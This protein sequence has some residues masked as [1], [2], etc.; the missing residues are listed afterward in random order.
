MKNI[1]TEETALKNSSWMF[2]KVNAI[3]FCIALFVLGLFA[4]LLQK[5]DFSEVEKRELAKIPTPTVE[6]VFSARFMKDFTAWYADTFPWRDSFITTG[7]MIEDTRG[8]RPD[9][10]KVYE[11]KAP[12]A[13][14]DPVVK[15]SEETS[16]P[17]E[18]RRRPQRVPVVQPEQPEISQP[19]AV[20]P[21]EP[22]PDHIEVVP[23]SDEDDVGYLMDNGIFVF[24]DRA[25]NLFGGSQRMADF[26]ASTLNSYVE[27]LDSSVQTYN[28]VVPCSAEFYLPMRYRSRSADQWDNISY[29][30]SQLDERIKTV[31]AYNALAAHA[32]EYIY[33]R[34]DHHWTALGAYYAYEV[35]CKEAG[36]TPVP[37]SDMEARTREGFL[38]TFYTQTGDQK[39]Q[40]NPDSLT[41]YIPD[42]EYQS[43]MR[44]KDQ[45]DSLTRMP[46]I[47]GE[48]AS[49]TNSYS[50][51]LYGDFPMEKIVTENQNGRKIV[52]VKESYGNAFVPFLLSHYEEIYVVDQRYFQTSL[53]DLIKENGITDLLFINNIF[54]ANT[55][56]HINHIDAMKH[57]VWQPPETSE[58]TNE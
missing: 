28:I 44:L 7:H 35:F 1:Y 24:G 3:G 4:L 37:L 38:G 58:Q 48:M 11:G 29:I 18:P 40:Q 14:A 45:P 26:Y 8:I 42:V 31:D 55:A 41:Y 2:T 5:P 57:Q 17:E 13:S 20:V 43:Y 54:A 39:L 27:E 22:K 49:M 12:S 50:I 15:P 46:G 30:Y 56:Y 34:T 32:D 16:R 25:V 53:M 36:F 51:F 21:E 19:E 6:T 33:F 47:W 52:V 23:P 9:D 10:V